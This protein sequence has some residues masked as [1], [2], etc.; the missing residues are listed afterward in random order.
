[1]KKKGLGALLVRSFSRKAPPSGARSKARRKRR[2][3]VRASGGILQAMLELPRGETSRGLVSLA[4]PARDGAP[5][6]AS[7]YPPAALVELP[8]PPSVARAMEVLGPS[9]QAR[10][11][12][13]ARHT[14]SAEALIRPDDALKQSIEA[15][16]LD[17]R[18]EHTK[19]A[20]GKD[21]KRFIQYLLQKRF[22]GDVGRIDRSLIVGYKDS[23][24][25]EGLQHT[26]IDR[27]LATLRSFFKWLADD[28]LISESPAARVR[29]INPR[30]LSTTVGFT[31]AEVRKVLSQPDL[32]TRVGALH[33]AILMVLFYC[34]LRRS[35]VCDIRMSQLL[36]ERD[37]R[38]LKLRG[39]GNHERVVVLIPPV[40]NAIQYYFRITGRSASQREDYL[41]R[42][43]RN[44][45]GHGTDKPIDP[46]LIF[47][48]VKRYAKLAGIESRV[49]PHSCRATAISNA[50]DHQVPDRAIQEFAGWASTAMI[51][52]YDK[53]RSSI[54][55]S[56]SHAI[57]YGGDEGRLMPID[58][59]RPAE[60]EPS[61]EN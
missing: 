43:I 28:G 2:R 56:A 54:E 39:K 46:S 51:T 20:Y 15:F 44:N 45:R 53:R 7:P 58:P 38:I 49:S 41:F 35:E 50:R 48:I 23:L 4:P 10:A 26:T 57:Q 22:A 3:P 27:H 17:Q 13:E 36:L 1:M 14:L 61:A 60:P 30:R 37:H 12:S 25:A 16:L 5:P 8:A 18:S 59:S 52:R 29:F 33:Y 34:G 11:G 47:Y 55:Q 9:A 32:H 19:R 40:W 31:D 21:L 24:L 6:L 42:P